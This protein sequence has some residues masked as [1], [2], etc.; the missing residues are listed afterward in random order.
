[1]CRARC[2]PREAAS[3][4][5]TARGNRRTCMGSSWRAT[6]RPDAYGRAVT[7][8]GRHAGQAGRSPK[9]PSTRS[10]ASPVGQEPGERP[11]LHAG[12]TG[13]GARCAAPAQQEAVQR[14]VAR[15]ALRLRPPNASA[16]SRGRR[17]PG[18]PGRLGRGRGAAAYPTDTYLEDIH[19]RHPSVAAACWA[20][21]FA[22]SFVGA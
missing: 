6:G 10:L 17:Q 1:M 22:H 18:A 9:S 3:R 20:A 5:P 11:A 13:A 14:S 8:R 15:Q 12:V 2:R 21:C 19:G 16:L 4:R 7:A